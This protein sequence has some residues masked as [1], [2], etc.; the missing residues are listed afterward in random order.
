M[1]LLRNKIHD[2]IIFYGLNNDLINN[3]SILN[4]YLLN[5]FVNYKKSLKDMHCQCKLTL[6][7][8]PIKMFS[9]SMSYQ[10]SGVK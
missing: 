6:Y 9:P 2:L 4:A 1:I 10:E 3:N 8:Q 5:Y 7:W